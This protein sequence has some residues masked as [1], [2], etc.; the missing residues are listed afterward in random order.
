MRTSTTVANAFVQPLIDRYL[1]RLE[2]ALSQSGFHGQFLLMQSSGGLISSFE[3]SR[4]LPCKLAQTDWPLV[5]EIYEELGAVALT[6]L[7]AARVRRGDTRIARRAEMR[8]AG[9]FHDI[10]VPVPSGELTAESA[11][12]L[13]RS[14]QAEYQRRYHA[15]LPGYDVMIL[16]WRL[17]AEGPEPVIRLRSPSS[18]GSG[19][20]SEGTQKSASRAF[21]GVRSAYFPEAGGFVSTPVYDR[22]L[23]RTQTSLDGPAIVEERE[24]TTVVGPGDRLMVDDQG[25]LRIAVAAG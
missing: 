16:N 6:T 10:E 19:R 14:F 12:E 8:L 23:L 13:S 24:S 20:P 17:R 22:Y 5:N 3:Y 2:D 21:K 15:V 11:S 7:K 9:Q 18:N 4:S 25:N 1:R